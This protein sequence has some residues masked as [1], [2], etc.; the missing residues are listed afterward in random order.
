MSDPEA[1]LDLA[2]AGAGIMQISLH[3]AAHEVAAGRLKRVLSEPHDPDEREVV[4]HYPHRQFLS[5]RVPWQGVN[6]LPCG[7]L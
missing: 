2:V 4:L 5:S 3:Y 1:Q 7:I 6:P